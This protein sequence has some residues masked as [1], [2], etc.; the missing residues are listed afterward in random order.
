MKVV[1]EE[2]AEATAVEQWEDPLAE[3]EEGTAVAQLVAVAEAAEDAAGVMAAAWMV[4]YWA[5]AAAVAM[6][7]AVRK[8]ARQVV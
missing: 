1:G 7:A 6:M 5:A 4:A 3:V 8:V 2:A